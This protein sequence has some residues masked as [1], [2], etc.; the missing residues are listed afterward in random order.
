VGHYRWPFEFRRPFQ[1]LGRKNGMVYP[2]FCFASLRALFR[3]P[4]RASPA[5]RTAK[6]CLT[7]DHQPSTSYF[8][9]PTSAFRIPH[10][11]LRL[12]TS[13]FRVSVPR[14][15]DG[16]IEPGVSAAN[17]GS[18][19]MTNKTP[20]NGVTEK[21]G[22][23]SMAL[24]VPSPLSGAW[25]KKPD[26]IP[27]V[28]LRFTPGFIPTALRAWLR[29]PKTEVLPRVPTSSLRVPTS[30]FLLPTSAFLIPTSDL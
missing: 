8:R 3:R 16:G 6:F 25:R 15:R 24:R 26:A 5:S 19:F 4:L 14:L 30:Y 7:F 1:G 23:L 29:F 10:S 9:L 12:P 11:D 21:R 2:E 13:D 27:G 22:T 18:R 20:F 28:L 17:S